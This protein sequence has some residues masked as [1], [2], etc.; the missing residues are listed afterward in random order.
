MKADNQLYKSIFIILILVFGVGVLY[1]IN[2]ENTPRFILFL[3]R[4][5]PLLLHLPI[6]ALVVTFFLDILSRF[7]NKYP[8][9][10]IRNLIGFTSIFA[11]VTCFLG[12]FLS[13]EGG[14]E[15]N[16]LD[17]HFY[18]G[19]GTAV[20]SCILFLLSLKPN[21]K[22]NKIFLPLFI[23]TLISISVTGHYGSILTHGDNFLT[24]YAGFEEKE[25]TIETIDSLKF[26]D[27]VISKILDSKCIQCHNASKQKGELSLNSKENILKG[28]IGGASTIA[29][30]A[31]ESL[32]YSRL[33]LPISDDDHMP[34][35][36]KEQLTKD[37]IW[38]IKHWINKGLDFENYATFNNTNDSLKNK[39]KK[40]L[41]FN[42]I[43]IPKAALNDI[44][45]AR[46]AGFRIHELVPGGSKLSVK[47]LNK[48][49]TKEIIE[50]LSDLKEQITELDLSNT[51][52]TND[53]TSV[54]KTFK[55][56]K[57]LRLNGTKITDESLQNIKNLSNLDVLNLFGTAISN[58][59]LTNL[60][61]TIQPKTIYTW[62]TNISNDNA[63]QLETQYKVRIQNAIVD[64]FVKK[65][66]LEIP[67]IT[68]EKTLFTD[69]IHI[70]A[71]SNIKDVALRYT[72]NGDLPDST[73]QIFD[74]KIILKNSKTLKIAAFKDSWFP[75]D[76]VVRE[77]TKTE[78][79]V[80]EF[81]MSKKPDERYP[82]AN[83]LFDF[84]EGSTNFKDGK[85]VG[86]FGEHL[87]SV[88]D[89]GSSK[90]INNVSFNS[91]EDVGRWILFPKEFIVYASNSK[92]GNYK[93]L[94]N[95][96]IER[97]GEGGA[98]KLKKITLNF[99]ETQARYFKIVIKSRKKMPEWHPARGKPCWIFID[100]I[101]FW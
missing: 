35:E 74:S 85:W 25:K 20:L 88:I 45:D 76:V 1:T 33:M 66:Q 19:I 46:L 93:K 68:P 70:N 24:E 54:L 92:R 72:I 14:Y 89:L 38:L 87:N 6:G 94:N 44:E 95:I 55:N 65:S 99:P 10:V 43:E 61:K 29:G 90:T 53:M 96:T 23:I 84:E 64:G 8:E 80:T 21:F 18:I 73:S 26:Y 7:Q 63:K 86:Y 22:A 13:L 82:D 15:K 4:F 2:T 49:P 36:G 97:E 37:E 47:L 9:T 52:L 30:N 51:A 71:K 79:K 34:P 81:V 100:E 5:H 50:E 78:N 12:Y 56:L 16:T 39:L 62:Q 32:L 83:K 91:L 17:L 69:T 42:K 58:D 98:P 41:I 75:S 40:Y 59:A 48:A 11:I 3:G 57:S 31:R 67:V 27:N 60:L 101:Y 28:G 77:L